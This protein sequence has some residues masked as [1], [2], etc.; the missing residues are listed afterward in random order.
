MVLAVGCRRLRRRHLPHDHP[1]LLQG[2][3]LPRRR[4][5][6]PRHEQRA[7]HGRRPAPQVHAH[8]L[9]PRSSSAGSPS[10]ACPPFAGFWSKDDILGVRLAQEH[11]RCTAIGLVTAVLTAYYMTREVI[12][13]FFGEQRWV[14]AV[15][16]ENLA[17]ADARRPRPRRARPRHARRRGQPAPDRARRAAL[18]RARRA[19][20]PARVALADDRAARGPG[21]PARCCR[22]ALPALPPHPRAL[23]RPRDP[24]RA[25]DLPGHRP[26]SSGALESFATILVLRRHR[27]RVLRVPVPLQDPRRA[28]QSS[29]RSPAQRLVLRLA[30]QPPS[31]EGPVASCSTGSPTCSTRAC[32]TGR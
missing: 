20:G 3:A 14:E 26:G 8:H 4:L 10:P 15:R 24:R 27:R 31:W 13:T 11:R 29:S 23:A 5:G 22:A 32:S 9:R 30:H 1:R 17:H 28:A 6:H 21:L 19:A 18:R 7:G 25:V 2:P 16:D 12:L